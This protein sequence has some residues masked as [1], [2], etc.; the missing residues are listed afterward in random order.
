MKLLILLTD[1]HGVVYRYQKGTIRRFSRLFSFNKW[2]HWGVSVTYG[3]GKDV[4][5]K[6]VM[7]RNDGEYEN[8]KDAIKA[9]KAFIDG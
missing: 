4:F 5:G 6:T 8:S 2:K 3:K 7:F 1:R 9:L